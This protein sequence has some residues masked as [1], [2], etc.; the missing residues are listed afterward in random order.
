MADQ[1]T[2]EQC[3]AAIAK[4]AKIQRRDLGWY[5]DVGGLVARI[6]SEYGDR[7]LELVAKRLARAGVPRVSASLLYKCRRL[8]GAMT[9]QQVMKLGR[10]GVSFHAAARL[11]TQNITAAQRRQLLERV[12]QGSLKPEQLV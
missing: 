6:P 9:R 10:Q 8:H 7:G 12:R 2:V 3:A 1:F 4:R 5:W 11:T